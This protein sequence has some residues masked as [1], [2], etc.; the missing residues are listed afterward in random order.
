MLLDPRLRAGVPAVA[1]RGWRDWIGGA[2]RTLAEGR[3]DLP[4][5]PSLP[6]TESLARIVRQV[7]L[8]AGTLPRISG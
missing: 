7:E 4:P 8:M 6:G 3:T 2:M 5:R 1:L